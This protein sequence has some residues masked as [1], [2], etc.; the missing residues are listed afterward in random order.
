MGFMVGFVGFVG[1]GAFWGRRGGISGAEYG[2]TPFFAL[3][4]PYI[5][6]ILIPP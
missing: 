2:G 6:P 3:F 4:L 5:L 1:E